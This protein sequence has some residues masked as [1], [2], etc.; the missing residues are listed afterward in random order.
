MITGLITDRG[1]KET[2]YNASD[3]NRVEAA[4][5]TIA[6]ILSDAGYPVTIST[7]TN[8]NV[9][10]F[11]YDTEMQR[12]LS[13]IQLCM[14]QFVKVPGVTLPESM[15]ALNYVGANNIEKIL[16]GLDNLIFQMQSIYLHSG[17]FAAGTDKGLR[18]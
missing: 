11:P 12:Y 9:T 10:D 5:R 17:T 15:Y 3:L 2:Y 13:N 18:R 7:R 1:N 4:T 16:Q 14:D 8:W 6:K